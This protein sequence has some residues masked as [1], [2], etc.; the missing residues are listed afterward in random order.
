MA[1]EAIASVHSCSLHYEVTG[2]GPPLVLI[3]GLGGSTVVWSELMPLVQD[4]WRVINVD[5]RG[6]GKTRETERAE[7]SLERWAS[8]LA[9]VLDAAAARRAVLVGHSLGIN[10]ALAYALMRPDDVGGLVL[11]NGEAFIGRLGE[12]LKGSI[13]GIRELGFE[14]WVEE[15]WSKNPPLSEASIAAHPELLPRYRAMVEANDPD[16]YVRVC[17]AISAAEDQRPFLSAVTAPAVVVAGELDDRMRPI[18]SRELADLLPNA[19]YVEIPGI[20][21]TAPFEAPEVVAEAVATVA[22]VARV[23]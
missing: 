19:S 18:V 5:L 23:N 12:R 9:A 22:N 1:T 14:S 16:D 6:C 2:D 4:D 17:E 13:D 21:H 8:D 15:R 10:I 20:G 7:L 11:V 3:H